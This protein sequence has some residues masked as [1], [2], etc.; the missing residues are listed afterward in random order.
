VTRYLISARVRNSKG[1]W[2]EMPLGV[3][4]AGSVQ[5]AAASARLKFPLPSQVERITRPIPEKKDEAAAD[6]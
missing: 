3:I 4:H 5:H 6:S 2:E 1:Q